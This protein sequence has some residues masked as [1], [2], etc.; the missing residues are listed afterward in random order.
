MATGGTKGK[1]GARNSGGSAKGIV[2]AR[3]ENMNEAKLLESIPQTVKRGEIPGFEF[4]SQYQLKEEARRITAMRMYKSGIISPS[5]IG[6]LE[7]DSYS[8]AIL[9]TAVERGWISK[10]VRNFIKEVD[11]SYKVK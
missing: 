9:D 3:E 2:A 8:N 1:S 6:Q 11:V 10:R 5:V 7:S 4:M